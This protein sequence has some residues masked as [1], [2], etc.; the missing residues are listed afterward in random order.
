VPPDSHRPRIRW[1]GQGAYL[2]A[3]DKA[4]P[5]RAAMMTFSPLRR[6]ASRSQVASLMVAALAASLVIVSSP[7]H[8]AVATPLITCGGHRVTI[9]ADAPGLTTSGTGGNDVM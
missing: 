2:S 9:R 5:E 8:V 3:W 1:R 6:S 4:Y 7:T